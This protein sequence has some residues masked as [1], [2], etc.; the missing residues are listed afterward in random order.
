MAEVTPPVVDQL[1][2][3]RYLIPQDLVLMPLGSHLILSALALVRAWVTITAMPGLA[4][5]G[6]SLAMPAAGCA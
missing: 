5:L 2:I 1:L 6:A 4:L 3:P